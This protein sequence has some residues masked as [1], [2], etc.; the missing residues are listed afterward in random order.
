MDRTEIVTLAST[1]RGL[2]HEP[3]AG[4]SETLRHRW[5]GALVALE[6]VLGERT[7]LVDILMADG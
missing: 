5:E 3:H 6:L 2:L 7:S 1:L 4:L